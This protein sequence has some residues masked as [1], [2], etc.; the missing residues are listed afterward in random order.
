MNAS[1]AKKLK[2]GDKVNCPAYGNG[3]VEIIFSDTVQ[4][5]FPSEPVPRVKY[6]FDQMEEWRKGHVATEPAK[7]RRSDKVKR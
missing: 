3:V 5:Y 6:G 1:A 7:K 4:A 2:V